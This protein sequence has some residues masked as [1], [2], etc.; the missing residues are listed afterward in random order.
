MSIVSSTSNINMTSRKRIV[1]GSSDLDN[2]TKTFEKHKA[3]A[4]EAQH[5]ACSL[6]KTSLQRKYSVSTVLENIG[7]T[8]KPAFHD[9]YLT[10]KSEMMEKCLKRFDEGVRII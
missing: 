6:A 5:K 7:L 9:I 3:P 2:T 1:K 10:K 8:A 4:I